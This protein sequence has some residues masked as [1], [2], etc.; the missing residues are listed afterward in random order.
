MSH[1]KLG[2]DAAEELIQ[3]LRLNTKGVVFNEDFVPESLWEFPS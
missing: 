2:E 3:E 1:H